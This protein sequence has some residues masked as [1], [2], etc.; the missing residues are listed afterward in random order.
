MIKILID[1]NVIIDIALEREPFVND[2]KKI[3]KLIEKQKIK[4][5]ISATTVTDIY[6]I[7]RQKTSHE[8]VI[9]F[10]ENLFVFVHVLSVNENIITKAM[11]QENK[12]FEDAVQ[13]ETSKQNNISVIITR[14]KKD[15]ENSGLK[16]FSP[17]EYINELKNKN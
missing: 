17:D 15:F 14:N 6:Y 4:A 3:I 13:I 10:F 8:Q 5:Y 1:T 7:T 11:K 9:N 12:D 2:A 16:I